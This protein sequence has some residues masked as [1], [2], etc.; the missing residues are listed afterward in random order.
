MG[1]AIESELLTIHTMWWWYAK[2]ENHAV[3]VLSGDRSTHDND[4]LRVAVT[5]SIFLMD[6]G[7]LVDASLKG[8]RK[9]GRAGGHIRLFGVWDRG[10]C[11][12]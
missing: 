4:L 6:R 7:F 9:G 8:L 11:W 3:R 5:E 2:Q 1:I 10:E 12:L